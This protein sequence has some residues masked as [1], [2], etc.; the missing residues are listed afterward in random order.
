MAEEATGKIQAETQL[1]QAPAGLLKRS[2]RLDEVRSDQ[3]LKYGFKGGIL[4]FVDHDGQ[5]YLTPGTRLKIDLLVECG[6][7]N[8]STQIEV[9]YSDGSVKSKWML[10]KEMP[11]QEIHRSLEENKMPKLEGRVYSAIIEVNLR[12]VKDLPQDFLARCGRTG[13]QFYLYTGLC[14]AYRGILAFT[15]E[16]AFTWVTPFSEQKQELLEQH[17]YQ[18]VES[19]IKVPYSLD[20]P[21]NTKWLAANIP[22]EEWERSQAEITEWRA[23]EN[24]A[25][26]RKK[27]EKLGLKDLP[28]ELLEASAACEESYPDNTGMCGSHAG[29]LGFTD[30]EGVTYVTPATRE[31]LETLKE[32]GYQFM[33]SSI[34]VPHSLK[35][36]QDVAWLQKNIAPEY[37]EEAQRSTRSELQRKQF[38]QAEKIQRKLGLQD[39]PADLTDRCIQTDA[40]QPSYIGEYFIRNDILGFVV[41]LGVVY[42]TPSTRK[43]ETMLK[44]ANY[45]QAAAGF[46]VPYSDGTKQDLDAIR[47]H[48]SSEEI[49][50]CRLERIEEQQRLEAKRRKKILE[51]IKLSKLPDKLI[52]RSTVTDEQNIELIGI[53]CSRIGMTCFVREDGWFYVTPTVPWKEQALR[54]AGYRQPEQMVRVPYGSGTDEDRAWLETNLPDGEFDLCREELAEHEQEEMSDSL[55]KKLEKL[56]IAEKLPEEIKARCASSGVKNEEQIGNYFIEN[57][58]TGIVGPDGIIWVTPC[59]VSTLEILKEAN[60]KYT[61]SRFVIPHGTD[62]EEDRLWLEENL[63]DGEL[64]RSRQELSQDQGEREDH[65]AADIA[66]Q[67]G[68]KELDPELIE[69]SG[70]VEKVSAQ[71]IGA[72]FQR[73]EMLLFIDATRNYYVTPHTTEKATMLATAGFHLQEGVTDLPFSNPSEEE[74]E[75]L[76]EMLPEG[77]LERCRQE[78]ENK[79][80]G[81]QDQKI[82]ESMEKHGLQPV[83]ETLSDRTADTGFSDPENVGRIGTY[84]GVMAFVLPDER[85][86]VTWYTPEKQELLEANGYSLEGRMPIKVPFAM[87][88]PKQRMWLVDHLPDPDEEETFSMEENE[89]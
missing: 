77:E 42:V 41:P 13:Q 72:Y 50:E 82:Q 8:P 24:L 40:K 46:N 44:E 53:Y 51:K 81:E 57:D 80:K 19:M 16:D 38:E 68:L 45:R 67:K 87:P 32:H 66:K 78:A 37:W 7:S 65:L 3:A 69:R 64:E 56:G 2:F 15:D 5:V 89:G 9:P 85:V 63:P 48:L 10:K 49:E 20:D 83:P 47:R 12:G 84:R 29:L 28:A 18:W 36:P 6:F 27:I 35:T 21:Q 25:R 43:K 71:R 73:R 86:M 76:I 39:L 74:H 55:K 4:A 26:A 11:R 33:G 23:K 79:E 59:T 61:T 1:R 58:L 34:R 62:L 60:Y 70:L 30:P 31:K 22:L 54:E 14:A 17:G 75:R 52:D 88:D